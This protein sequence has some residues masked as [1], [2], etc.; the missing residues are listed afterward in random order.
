[1]GFATLFILLVNRLSMALTFAVLS[2]IGHGGRG[3]ATASMRGDYFGRKSFGTIFGLSALPMN[4]GSIVVPLLMGVAFDLT[5]SY[6]ASFL[7]LGLLILAGAILML[8]L[9]PP[10]PPPGVRRT[11]E[12]R[13]G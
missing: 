7:A 5:N 8:F 9:R 11:L 10:Q 4:L 2:G 12:A 13:I 3:P 1:H 6:R